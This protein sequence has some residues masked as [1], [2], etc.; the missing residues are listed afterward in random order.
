[1]FLFLHCTYFPPPCIEQHNI[2]THTTSAGYLAKRRCWLST[3]SRSRG[4]YSPYV[5]V[6]FWLFSTA[7]L[8]IKATAKY[9]RLRCAGE[10]RVICR[11]SSSA[12]QWYMACLY[13]SGFG[14]CR[15]K[16]HCSTLKCFKKKSSCYTV[17]DSEVDFYLRKGNVKSQLITW[18]QNS[19][20][21]WHSHKAQ[22]QNSDCVQI[23]GRLRWRYT[24][25][26]NPA[27]IP[28]LIQQLT[29]LIW[30]HCVIPILLNQESCQRHLLSI[31]TQLY[32]TALQALCRT[33][34]K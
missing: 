30:S 32:Y 1:M 25:L 16:S 26:L 14:F 34:H 17:V 9:S 28:R 20:I 27:K 22:I 23:P 6:F 4:L 3:R 2:R 29:W 15:T 13:I 19:A 12:F 5:H 33:N 8:D 7:N 11:L 21:A 10:N 31:N 18:L 24:V